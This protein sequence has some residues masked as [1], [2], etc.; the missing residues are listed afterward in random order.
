MRSIW[1]SLVARSDTM[2]GICQALGSDFGISPNWFRVAFA[3]GV[4]YNIEWSVG[5]YL[6]AGLIVGLAHLA[7]PN[8]RR[9]VAPEAVAAAARAAA[10]PVAAPAP[11]EPVLEA[12]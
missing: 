1:S 8:K 4:I 9:A 5:A 7:H 3:A 12:A 11:R 6:A 2:F 10:E